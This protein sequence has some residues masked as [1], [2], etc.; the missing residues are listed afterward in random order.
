MLEFHRTARYVVVILIVPNSHTIHIHSR[1][2][3]FNIASHQCRQTSSCPD[4]W[5]ETNKAGSEVQDPR[6]KNHP[7]GFGAPRH[8]PSRSQA[9]TAPYIAHFQPI[10]III[11]ISHLRHSY[12]YGYDDNGTPA[13]HDALLHP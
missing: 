10:I 3:T 13:L 8:R 9:H 5:Q 4:H 1:L 7:R 12:G 11:I 6:E 2:F